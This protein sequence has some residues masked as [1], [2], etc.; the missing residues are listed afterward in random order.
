MCGAAAA[1]RIN[2]FQAWLDARVSVKVA[3]LHVHPPGSDCISTLLYST[4]DELRTWQSVFQ[5]SI[6]DRHSQCPQELWL[7]LK[8]AGGVWLF[9]I[10]F[11]FFCFVFHFCYVSIGRKINPEMSWRSWN[12]DPIGWANLIVPEQ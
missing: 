12:S 5:K 1:S 11:F 8:Q 7:T 4:H 9:F 6:Y 2:E 10:F 3:P